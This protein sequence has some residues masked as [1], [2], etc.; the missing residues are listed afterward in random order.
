MPRQPEAAAPL[1]QIELLGR[2]VCYTL[3]RSRRR[4]IGLAIDH[5]GLRVGAPHA[6]SQAAIEA[7]L[8]QHGA[9]V[10]AK[11][12]DWNQRPQ[13]APVSF[14]EGAQWPWLGGLLTLHL[15]AAAGRRG[16]AIWSPPNA[17]DAHALTLCLPAGADV[18]AYCLR[19]LRR[20]AEEFLGERLRLGVA[21]AG[22]PLPPFA[23]S[24]AGSRWGSC[25]SKG[26][27][28][29][30]WRLMFCPLPIID[31]VVAHELAHLKEM[32]HSPRFWSEVER[33]C[34]E[35]RRWRNELREFG[36]EIPHF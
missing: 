12:D 20:R 22:V 9:W 11:L 21:R 7:L 24:S 14:V 17:E 35:W 19:A 5:R 2:P 33:L 15:A 28:R 25:S 1:R 27:I 8:Q 32:N 26:D 29:L 13:A 16:Q 3:R 10:I 34:P 31:Y 4:T 6:A 23:L 36:R 18:R 30:S